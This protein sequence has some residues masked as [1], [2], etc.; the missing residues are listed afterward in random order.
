[1]PIEKIR[2]K[3]VMRFSVEREQRQ[4][5]SD[6]DDDEHD[7]RLTA[8]EHQPDE[9]ADG[10]HGQQHVGQELVAPLRR[11]IAVVACDA[12]MN[13]RW[14]ECALQRVELA[15]NAVTDVDRVGAPALGH[16]QGHRW[17]RAGR[18]GLEAHVRRRLGG[19]VGDSGDV[20]N[21]EP[22]T[23]RILCN[24]SNSIRPDSRLEH[25]QEI[26]SCVKTGA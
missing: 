13:I 20:A 24:H 11:R 12:E 25:L 19:G 1:M 15:Q 8:A 6:R 16:A 5:E 17:R 3:S 9:H 26:R 18:V 22:A 4:R 21:T 10:E 14:E 2:A 23:I 7:H